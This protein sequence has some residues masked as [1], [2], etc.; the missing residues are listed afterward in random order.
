MHII[1]VKYII[2]L[3]SHPNVASCLNNKEKR[4]LRHL[5]IYFFDNLFKEKVWRLKI[6]AAQSS[7]GGDWI[8]VLYVDVR[9]R[10]DEIKMECWKTIREE[11]KKNER[12]KE[13]NNANLFKCENILNT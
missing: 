9:W 6:K 13:Y 2:L 12:Q 7:R 5:I 8:R 1:E 10:T 4:I 3:S 11:R